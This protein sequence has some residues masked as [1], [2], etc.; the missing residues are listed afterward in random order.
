[1]KIQINQLPE[2]SA[3]LAFFDPFWP[4]IES[5]EGKR[6]AINIDF[7]PSQACPRLGGVLA[8]PRIPEK[9][10]KPV[11]P[12]FLEKQGQIGGFWGFLGF[13]GFFK[14]PPLGGAKK[15]KNR[16]ISEKYRELQL[17]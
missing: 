9:P 15:G 4:D 7:S 10:E 8:P 1:M 17:F 11:L 5:L 13:L 14:K 3:F 12:R 16:A 6:S 2:K